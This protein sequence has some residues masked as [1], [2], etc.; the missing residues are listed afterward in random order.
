MNVLFETHHERASHA[1]KRHKA[2]RTLHRSLPT[3]AV[4]TRRENNPV[5][6]NGTNSGLLFSADQK[7][8][9]LKTQVDALEEENRCLQQIAAKAEASA[10]RLAAEKRE[11]EEKCQQLEMSGAGLATDHHDGT[12]A[13]YKATIERLNR[14]IEEM[15][16][17]QATRNEDRNTT[18]PESQRSFHTAPDSKLKDQEIQTLREAKSRADQIIQGPENELRSTQAE[19]QAL[20]TRTRE[21]KSVG[22]TPAMTRDVAELKSVRKRI[23]D[24]AA[25][26][27][28]FG[29]ECREARPLEEFAS[30]IR[31]IPLSEDGAVLLEDIWNV[32]ESVLQIKLTGMRMSPAV[33]L[34]IVGS[35]IVAGNCIAEAE[36]ECLL[37]ALQ[38]KAIGPSLA[39][40]PEALLRT[41]IGK[42]VS[43]ETAGHE[44]DHRLKPHP[45]LKNQNRTARKAWVQSQQIESK[46]SQP[47]A[48]VGSTQVSSRHKARA[49]DVLA[50]SLSRG[51]QASLIGP[52]FLFPRAGS[53]AQQTKEE[54]TTWTIAI[55]RRNGIT[56][57]ILVHK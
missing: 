39:V 57:T 47:G 14:T 43:I 22:S 30:I 27:L 41:I 18:E 20:R 55:A 29:T 2:K 33:A 40:D 45:P 24:S 34:A 21:Q 8:E 23:T 6:A 35:N 7:L 48:A 12:V 53:D 15:R 28:R 52:R 4:V 1:D 16:G 54:C 56:Q 10:Q 32:F 51:S 46:G 49:F 3:T 25:Q 9:N 44:N 13:E 17:Q 11:L 42:D 36:V 37:N 50:D 31:A 38:V 26:Q 5:T 19:V